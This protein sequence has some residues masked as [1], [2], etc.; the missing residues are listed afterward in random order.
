MTMSEINIKYLANDV[1]DTLKANVKDIPQKI[2]DNPYD[3]EWLNDYAEKDIYVTK[4]YKIEDFNLDI[5]TSA[6]DKDIDIKNSITLYEHLKKLPNYV[7]SDERFWLW[8]MFEKAYRVC[9]ILMP[10][11]SA[12]SSV[13]KDHWLFSS[14]N[15]RGLFFGALSRCYYRV[16]MTVDE[17]LTDPYELTKFV[18]NFPERFRVYSWRSISSQKHVLLGV[19]KA[20]K[21]IVEKY[22]EQNEVGKIYTELAKDLSKLG[23]VKL[24]DVMEEEEIKEY[25][26]NKYKMR[27]EKNIYDKASLLATAKEIAKI[28]K[29]IDLFSTLDEYMDSKDKLLKCIEKKKLATPK[30][31]FLSKLKRK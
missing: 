13:F 30:R 14:G 10:I 28:E 9:Q 29:A 15:R 18:I 16:S 2:I 22:G 27:I 23:S 17:T 31:S 25:I 26:Y 20:E 19:L 6:D 24:I 7:L 5:P 11:K 3:T 4:K 1:L 12:D 8:L 21:E